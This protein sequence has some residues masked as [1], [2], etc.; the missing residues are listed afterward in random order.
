MYVYLR[1]NDKP[2]VDIS[3]ILVSQIGWNDGDANKDR[4]LWGQPVNTK[5][6]VIIYTHLVFVKKN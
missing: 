5:N 2:E 3:D 4:R 1:L 6:G